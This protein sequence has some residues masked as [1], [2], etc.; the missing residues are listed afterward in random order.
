MKISLWLNLIKYALGAAVLLAVGVLCRPLYNWYLLRCLKHNENNGADA[1]RN[2]S[3]NVLLLLSQKAE[4]KQVCAVLDDLPKLS[5]RISTA[6][7]FVSLY[8]ANFRLNEA[9]EAAQYW[10]KTADKWVKAHPDETYH[11]TILLKK[12]NSWYLY[13]HDENTLYGENA[14]EAMREITRLQGN[15]VG[16][17]RNAQVAVELL[18]RLATREKWEIEFFAKEFK[19][20]RNPLLPWP[21]IFDDG[22]AD[23]I[24]IGE[25]EFKAMCLRAE[26]I[27]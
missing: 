8:L 5:N 10:F 9:Q 12:L 27:E 4:W 17:R 7:A 25:D 15:I 1:S 23:I 14:M 3:T 6:S 11:A 20:K 24:D 19:W 16:E 18:K 13:S 26:I 2:F 21:F 22:L